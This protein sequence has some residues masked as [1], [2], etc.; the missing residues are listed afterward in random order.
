MK[1]AVLFY[2]LTVSY[3]AALAPAQG[4]YSGFDRNDYPGDATMISL[5]K[6]FQYTS[7]WLNRP[8]GASHNSWVGKKIIHSAARLWLHGPVQRQAQR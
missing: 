1:T 3:L 4:L 8:P 2:A 5:R 6:T 7:Y